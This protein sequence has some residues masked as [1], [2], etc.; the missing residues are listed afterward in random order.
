[1]TAAGSAPQVAIPGSVRRR[2]LRVWPLLAA[3]WLSVA[4]AIAAIAAAARA[5]LPAVDVAAANDLVRTAERDWGHLQAERMDRAGVDY[6]IVDQGGRVLLSRGVPVTDQ[7]AAARARAA[8]LDVTRAGAIVG[9]VY[10]ADPSAA[11]VAERLGAGVRIAAA[12]LV[13]V[14][15]AVTAWVLWWWRRVVVPFGRLQEF[16]ADVAAGRLD[17]PLRMDR[18]HLFG[19]FTESFDI[20]R[21]ELS[22][23]RAAER[24]AAESKRT[25]V[26]QLGHDIRTPLASLGAAAELLA[27]GEMDP[28]RRE[29]LDIVLAKTAQIDA[30]MDE[31]FEANAEQLQALPVSCAPTPS[32]ELAR[33]VRRADITGLVSRVEL[34]EALLDVDPRRTQ[35]ILDNVLANV[36]KY[37]APPGIVTGVVTAGLYAVTIRDAGPGVA[38]ED[39]PRLTAQRFRG[40]NAGGAPGFGLGLFTA[41]WLMER[42]GGALTCHNLPDGF[43]VVL[44]FRLA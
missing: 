38:P 27:V 42:M 1:M 3:L 39:L 34:P 31:L 8:T 23:A 36:A 6:T 37:G 18:G 29:R 2:R 9:R 5:P 19:A 4:L 43:A 28:V 13:A 22:R 21:S 32:D 33:Q 17:A 10:V 26:S 30:L 35:Q 16:A 14:A 41:G 20:L 25:L 11:A 44:E 24:D 12:A 40:G 7:L 15:L